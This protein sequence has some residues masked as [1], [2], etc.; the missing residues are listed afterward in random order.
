MNQLLE[1]REGELAA[2]PGFRHEAISAD[3]CAWGMAQ[4]KRQ[5]SGQNLPGHALLLPLAVG[6]LR[7]KILR[8]FLGACSVKGE[9]VE[10]R[11]RTLPRTAHAVAVSERSPSVA[12][13]Q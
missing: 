13:E 11:H 7:K 3:V 1:A 6:R 12:P 9:D 2:F 5:S 8:L 4:R 10:R